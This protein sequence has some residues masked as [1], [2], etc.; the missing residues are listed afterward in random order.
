[1]QCFPI[2][3]ESKQPSKSFSRSEIF[4]VRSGNINVLKQLIGVCASDYWIEAGAV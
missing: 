1:M 3:N 2:P 4:S